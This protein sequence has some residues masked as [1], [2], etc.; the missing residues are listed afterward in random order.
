MAV[1]KEDFARVLAGPVGK[2][3]GLHRLAKI[4]FE[5]LA[6][7][8]LDGLV[9][10]EANSALVKMRR[11]ATETASIRLNTYTWRAILAAMLQAG[12]SFDGLSDPT[13]FGMRVMCLDTIP[14]GYWE[15]TNGLQGTLASGRVT[16]IEP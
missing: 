5:E 3:L 8:L 9:Q 15:V 16:V 12:C 1:S 14:P 10:L 11:V 13:L 4:S 7:E 6:S 2:S